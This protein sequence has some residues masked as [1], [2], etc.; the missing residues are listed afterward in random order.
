MRELRGP[1]EL[2]SRSNQDTG[3][4]KRECRSRRAIRPQSCPLTP[5]LDV[6]IEG[7][8]GVGKWLTPAVLKT[9]RPQKGLVGSNPT[10]SASQSGHFSLL[11]HFDEKY[12]FCGL[13]WPEL[14]PDQRFQFLRPARCRANRANFLRGSWGSAFPIGARLAEL[15]VNQSCS[16][17]GGNRR[18]VAW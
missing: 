6:R 13:K 5:A 16:P 10:P 18:K 7:I 1:E 8:G 14:Q 17:C 3:R 2:Q 12:R 11:A 15:E 4:W 9:V